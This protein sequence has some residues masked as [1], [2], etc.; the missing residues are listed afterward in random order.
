MTSTGKRARRKFGNRHAAKASKRS[1]QRHQHKVFGKLRFA[2]HRD[3]NRN[4]EAKPIIVTEVP[5][6]PLDDGS[7]S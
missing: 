2:V 7:F 3:R 1:R 4:P 5:L 6:E